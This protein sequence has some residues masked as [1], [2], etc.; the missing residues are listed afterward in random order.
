M[1]ANNTG[2]NTSE[3]QEGVTEL[4][5][6]GTII[7]QPDLRGSSKDKVGL[8]RWVVNIFVGSGGV[9]MK[10]IS[11]YDPRYNRNVPTGTSYQQQRR[12]FMKQVAIPV[13]EQSFDK[14]WL[15]I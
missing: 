4:L 9:K 11:R 3:T 10:L 14:T 12:Y 8:A 7:D 6:Y 2:K 13:Q 5:T 15:H 1:T